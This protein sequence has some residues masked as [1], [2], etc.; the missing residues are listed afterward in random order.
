MVDYSNIAEVG[1]ASIGGG[2]VPNQ[3]MYPGLSQMIVEY[4]MPAQIFRQMYIHY[5]S[6]GRQAVTIPKEATPASMVGATTTGVIVGSRVG[7]GDEMPLNIL[8]VTSDTV[9]TYKVGEGYQVTREMILFQ[10]V[11]IIQQRLKRLGITLGNTI[12]FDCAATVEAAVATTDSGIH[13]NVVSG[14]TKGLDNTVAVEAGTLG[15]YDFVD[16]KVRMMQNN[17]FADTLIVQPK[18]AGHI[19]KLPQFKSY[20]NTG[21][22]G[23]YA[24]G[25]IGNVEGLRVLVSRHSGAQAATNLVTDGIN[26]VMTGTLT[27]APN[28]LGQ[29]TPMGYFVESLPIQTMVQDNPRRDAYEVYALCM[30]APVVVTTNA[31]ERLSGATN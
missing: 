11:P 12:D 9:T 22:V 29:Y 27:T 4:A 23:G 8:P 31:I 3:L 28:P 1:I 17:L 10:Q 2:T 26:Y 16:A 25:E 18:G 14:K 13:T 21:I 20:M 24:H 30:F 19:A 7:E 5:P 6:M 15:Q